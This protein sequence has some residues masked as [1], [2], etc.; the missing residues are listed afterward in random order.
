MRKILIV[1]DEPDVRRTVAGVFS[2]LYEVLEAGDGRE[3]LEILSAEEPSVV[4]LDFSLPGMSGIDFLRLHRDQGRRT[5]I[6]MLT[7][8]Q[9]LEVARQALELGA[10][11]FVTK[12]FETDY[13]RSEVSRIMDGPPPSGS[14]RDTRPWR[15]V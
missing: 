12:P 1:D 4:L 2:G 5:A 10:V 6:I 7:C 3:A 9:D 14:G 11:E 8:E 15:T 13:L